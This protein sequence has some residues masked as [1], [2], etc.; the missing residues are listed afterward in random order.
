MNVSGIELRHPHF[1]DGLTAILAETGLPAEYLKLE[2]TES[3]L[4]Q[5][6]ETSQRTLDALKVIGVGL[7]IDDFGIGYSSLSYLKRFP[8]DTLKID[9]SFVRDMATDPD[10]AAIVNAVIGMGRNLKQQVVAEGVESLKQLMMLKAQR[11]ETGQ[12]FQFSHPLSAEA[13]EYLLAHQKDSLFTH[14]QR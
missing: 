14:E 11:C 7:A 4:I 8:I 13:F 12:G 5:D 10:D 6:S 9:R 1:V 3:V 2:L